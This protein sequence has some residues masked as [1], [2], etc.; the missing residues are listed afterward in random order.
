MRPPRAGSESRSTASAIGAGSASRS[1]PSRASLGWKHSASARTASARYARQQIQAV[2]PA[3]S[4]AVRSRGYRSRAWRR[5]QRPYIPSCTRRLQPP[6]KVH[7]HV[8]AERLDL[9]HAPARE[10]GD[11]AAVLELHAVAKP[12]PSACG[13]S[14]RGRR[15][16]A[17][18]G[19]PGSRGAGPRRA[20]SRR[21]PDPRGGGAVLRCRAVLG[22]SPPFLS[23]P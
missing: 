5:A 6:S 9:L 4:T 19:G 11:H 14:R 12:L 7:E 13:G 17:R 22:D 23:P 20:R 21:G 3:T 8:L 10:L 1:G 2:S 18:P 16:H 15:R